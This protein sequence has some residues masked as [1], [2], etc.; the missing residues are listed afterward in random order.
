MSTDVPWINISMAIKNQRLVNQQI[1]LPIITISAV[2]ETLQRPKCFHFLL[3]TFFVLP[4][5]FCIFS[6]FFQKNSS[7]N[8]GIRMK[9]TDL[10]FLQAAFPNA[11]LR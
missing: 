5:H 6:V 3:A 1:V 7:N 9:R 2:S 8:S 11:L 10:N 4:Q